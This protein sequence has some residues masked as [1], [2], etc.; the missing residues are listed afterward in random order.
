MGDDQLAPIE[1]IASELDIVGEPGAVFDAL[2]DVM[3]NPMTELRRFE[4][5]RKGA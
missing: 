3:A 2:F 1:A 5:L 4:M